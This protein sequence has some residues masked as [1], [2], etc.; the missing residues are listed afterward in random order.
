M[1]RLAPLQALFAG[2]FL[3]A[4]VDNMILFIVLAIIKRD[5][6]PDYYLSYV[7]GLIYRIVALG[8]PVCR[9]EFKGICACYR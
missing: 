4:F 6:Y 2:Q 7:F 1:F 8:R 5:V 9:Q 3:S